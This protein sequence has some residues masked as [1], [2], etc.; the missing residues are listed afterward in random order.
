MEIQCKTQNSEYH[1]EDTADISGAFNPSTKRK[2]NI[3]PHIQTSPL[4]IIPEYNL[5]FK[6]CCIANFQLTEVIFHSSKHTEKICSQ[7]I[8]TF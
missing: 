4:S 1:R 2:I 5:L 8:K 3:H 7:P 6:I